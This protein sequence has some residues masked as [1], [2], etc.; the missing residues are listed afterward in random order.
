MTIPPNAILI[1]LTWV[2]TF[3]IHKDL[4]EIGVRTSL[5]TLLLRD[6]TAYLIRIVLI[7]SRYYIRFSSTEATLL[8]IWP[9][10]DQ[11]WSPILLSRFLLSAYGLDFANRRSHMSVQYVDSSTSA[12]SFRMPNIRLNSSQTLG[13]LDTTLPSPPPLEDPSDIELPSL[14]HLNDLASGT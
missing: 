1:C 3:S 12:I 14:G 6:G 2:K 9:Y 8:S 13:N 11:V 5:T 10:F 4:S 7:V